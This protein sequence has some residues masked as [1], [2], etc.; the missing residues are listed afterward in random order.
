[1]HR[2]LKLNKEQEQ[3]AVNIHRKSIIIDALTLMFNDAPSNDSYFQL[4][5]DA[6]ITATNLTVPR[7]L[8]DFR[9]SLSRVSYWHENFHRF[10]RVLL[11]TSAQ[12]IEK[13]K[14][15][16]KIAIIM[17]SQ[18]GAIIESDIS[19]LR[20]FY[21][22]DLRILQ[23]TYQWRN[24][25]GD[26][27]GERTDCGLS[28]FGLQVVEEMNR[29]GFLIDLSHVGY[30][31]TMEVIELSEDP[32]VFTHTN[33]RALCDHVRCKSDEQIKALAEK[34]GVMGITAFAPIS[35]VRKG[36]RATIED[37]LDC[38][39]HVVKLVGVDHVGIGSDFEPFATTEDHEMA[40][41]RFPEI[42]G[43]YTLQTRNVEGLEVVSN[44][45]DITRGL[46]GRGYADQEIEKI[47]GGNFLRVFRRVWRK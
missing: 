24:L 46:V 36:V 1:M 27:C 8:D 32:V 25:I 14:M 18:N 37:Y 17:G 40:R 20:I 38:I 28:K 35:E 22:L 4:M 12:D 5:L 21:A 47:L 45:I 3:R 9:Q 26:G 29:I 23:L 7:F 31:T 43:T 42:I 16:R 13:A 6:G 41:K 30:R 33:P 2:T 19:L 44:F 10:G 11:A 39:D 15:T 34:G